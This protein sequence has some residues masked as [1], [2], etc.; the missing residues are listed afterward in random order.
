MGKPEWTLSRPDTAHLIDT[1]K[2]RNP[3]IADAL[4]ADQGVR[5]MRIDSDITIRAMRRCADAGIPV[6][7]VHDAMITPARHQQRV[8]G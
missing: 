4:H 6:L 2:R 5:L 3:T 7:P 8:A 1:L